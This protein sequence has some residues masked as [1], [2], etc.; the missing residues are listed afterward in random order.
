MIVSD[1]AIKKRTGVVVLAIIIIIAGLFSYFELPRENE[2]DITIPYA[3]ISTTYRGVSPPD[4]ETSV[5][6]PIEK[7]LTGL[8]N[9]KEIK[10][11]SSEGSSS[12]SIEFTTET[13]IDYALQKVKDKVDEA[14]SDL[15]LDLEDDPVVYEVNFSEMPIVVFSLSGTVDHARLKHI[16]DNLADEIETITGILEVE[17]TGGRER[18]IR[19]EFMPE[20]LAYF[21][22]SPQEV[23]DRLRQENKNVSGGAMRMGDGRFKLRTPGELKTPDDFFHLLVGSRNG[24]PIF[25][26]DVALV[27]DGF[28]EETSRSRIDGRNAVNISVKKRAGENIIKI[29]DQIDTLLDR[30]EPTWP[31]GTKITKVMDKA[32]EI[33]LMVADLENNLMTGLVLVVM[34]LFLALG[35]R[36][37]VLVSLAIPFS[38]F[39][40]FIVLHVMGIT[41]NMVVLFSLTLALGMLVDNAIVII[42]NIYRFTSQ[43]VD[44]VQAAM[45]ATSEVA[46]P[47]IGST[48]TTLAAFFPMIF[49]PGIMGEFMKYLPITLIITL[50][51]SLFVAMI[52]NPALASLLLKEGKRDFQSGNE[53]HGKSV[54]EMCERPI[55]VKGVILKSYKR[56][57]EMVLT[58]RF[59]M[60][61]ISFCLIILVF[62]AW[63]LRVGLERPVEFFPDL[64]PPFMYVNMDM[65]EGA[66]LALC[67]RI[68]KQVEM[69]V[70]DRDAATGQDNGYIDIKKYEKS[71]CFKEHRTKDGIEYLSVSDLDNIENVYSTAVSVSEGASAIFGGNTPSHVGVQFI[72]FNDR[73]HPSKKTLEKIH[74]RI[75]RIAGAKITI[76]EAD[77]GPPTGPPVNIEISGEDFF[78]LNRLAQAIK[79]KGAQIPGIYDI[80]DDFEQGSPTIRLKIDRQ[81]AALSGLSSAGVGKAL[82]NAYN[83]VEVST[84]RE[85]DE[86][87]DITVQLPPENRSNT[88]TL[89]N[90]LIAS[91]DGRLIP[92]STLA[93]FEYTGSLGSI[94]RINNERV[95]TVKANVD[96]GKIPAAVVR[97]RI[98]EYLK[99]MDLPPGY[100]VQLTGEQE[101]QKKSEDFLKKAFIIAIFLVSLVLITQFNSIGRPLIIMTAVILSLGG[102]F[103]GLAIFNMSFGI[104]MTGV[105]II[106]L[107]GVVVNNG[108]VLI[109]YVNQLR[110]R[111][112]TCRDAVVAAGCTRLRPVLLTA[113]T[114]TLGLI[115]MVTGISYDFHVMEISWMSESSQYWRSMAM[116]VIFGL[117]LA[118][119]LT[120]AVVPALYSS[121]DSIENFAR[122]G[123]TKTHEF[124]W[125]L[126][127]KIFG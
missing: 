51:S 99:T 57:L 85:E 116:A 9:V 83:G 78:V 122:T 36:N 102:A 110:D 46:Y 39:L 65:P 76:K 52:I 69:A 88:N 96:E 93:D 30:L 89:K 14:N 49:W 4:I 41:L 115:P 43:G 108:I 42:E 107:A 75:A 60:L 26:S 54:E 121:L 48:V 59:A 58:H 11:V 74:E 91:P 97:V 118:T 106:S 25:L 61:F 47:V 105:G 126:Y 50:S 79:E 17:V 16:A 112:M 32:E 63:I 109:D 90:L 44:R 94:I 22:L 100:R 8:E 62:E 92:L 127:E 2:P 33:R 84:Y 87:Y 6:I 45:R 104:I 81:K 55:E 34:V 35:L 114:T 117:M 71:L 66:D 67:D 1:T 10:S 73:P 113:I 37:A 29:T 18:E 68:A 13:D 70:C 86:D 72:D 21:G 53:K 28:K 111:G 12:I 27:S 56:F 7:K 123:W 98:E 20:K 40:S 125:R 124:Y 95:I 120:L 31:K 5:T 101:H 23:E 80:Q 77:A 38:M 3:F 19:V 64:D 103:L 15:P 119:G 24:H 82:K